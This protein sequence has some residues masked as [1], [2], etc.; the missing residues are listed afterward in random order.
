MTG[1]KNA[2]G[3]KPKGKN[4]NSKTVIPQNHSIVKQPSKTFPMEGHACDWP[5][6]SFSKRRS[7]VTEL[8]I[9]YPDSSYVRISAPTGFPGPKFPGYLDVILMK[10]QEDLFRT[11]YAEI[12][13]YDIF[14]ELGMDPKDGRNYLRFRRDMDRAAHMVIVTDRFRDPQTGERAYT[15]YYRILNTMKIAHR[16]EYISRF[17][18][19]ESFLDSLRAS[20]IKRLD[21]DFCLYLDRNEKALARFLYGHIYARIGSKAYYVRSLDGFLSDIGMGYLNNLPAKRKNQALKRSLLPALKLV[22]GQAFRNYELDGQGNIVFYSHSAQKSIEGYRR[23]WANDRE[24]HRRIVSESPQ[25]YL[26]HV[27]VCKK[28][29]NGNYYPDLY[30]LAKKKIGGV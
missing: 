3:Q 13:V 5:L 27:E 24:T 9:D 28:T 16:R 8:R 20:Y 4:Q 26:V 23:K 14:R 19:N 10:T 30:E 29:G 1:K 15:T 21:Y 17:Y 22:E 18:L 7:T 11:Q 25:A 6:W 12:S 2:P